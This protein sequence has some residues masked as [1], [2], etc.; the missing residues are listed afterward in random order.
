MPAELSP[1]L[2]CMELRVLAALLEKEI[3]TPEYYP[4]SLNALS[5]ACNQKTNREPVSSFSDDEVRDAL[6]RLRHRGLSFVRTGAGSRVEKFGS[7]LQ[8]QIE[9]RPRRA[10]R[11]DRARCSAAR[12][13]SANSAPAPSACTASTTSTR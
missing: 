6:E 12:K 11:P 1:P 5:N 10:R 9:F 4:L 2:D 8:E 13:P 3:T 7:R